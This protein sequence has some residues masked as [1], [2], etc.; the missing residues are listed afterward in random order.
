ML[1]IVIP[2]GQQPANNGSDAQAHVTLYWPTHALGEYPI[3]LATGCSV[4]GHAGAIFA[5]IKALE[6]YP[7]DGSNDNENPLPTADV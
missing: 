1:A 5:R 6:I 4:I 7:V 2:I 3:G